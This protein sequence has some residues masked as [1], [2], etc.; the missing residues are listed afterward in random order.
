MKMIIIFID[1]KGGCLQRFT[2]FISLVLI[3]LT[4]CASPATSAPTQG[5]KLKVVATTTILGDVVGAIG[6]DTIDLSVLLPTG[7]DPHGF[8]PTPQDVTRVADADLIFANGAGLEE[9]LAPL[10]ENA[11]AGDKTVSVSEGIDLLESSGQADEHASSDPHVWMDPNNVSIWAEA[12][13]TAL[14]EAD[15]ANASVYEANARAY[16]EQLHTL[17]GWVWE[18]VNQIPAENRKLVTDHLVFAYFTKRYGF[19]QVGAIVPGYSTLAQPAAQDLAALEDAIRALHVRAVFV[20][21]TV[22]PALSRRVSEDTGTRLVFLYTGSL[23][24]PGGPASTYIELIRY[25]VN[26]IVE[27]LK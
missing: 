14:S 8:E 5:G 2:I 7:I 12:I 9:F 24:E 11:G 4:G 25:N 17:D 20:G 23:S 18:Q 21:N 15:P 26:A 3:L 16:K 22:N 19:E 13:Q 6:A 27:A 10:L 1:L